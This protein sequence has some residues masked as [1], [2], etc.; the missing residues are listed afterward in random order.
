MG[1]SCKMVVSHYFRESVMLAA[2]EDLTSVGQLASPWLNKLA[3]VLADKI[4]T[5]ASRY[6]GA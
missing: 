1:C 3:V 4:R 2:R 5:L 6:I